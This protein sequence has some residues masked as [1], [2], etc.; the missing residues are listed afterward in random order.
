MTGFVVDASVTASWVLPD[1]NVQRSEA[2]R[3]RLVEEDAHVPVVW[4]AEAANALLIAERRG[5]VSAEDVQAALLDLRLSPIVVDEPD[6]DRIW[7]ETVRL[8]REHRLTVYDASYLE[9]ALRL[10]LPLATL[11][12][13]LSEAATRAGAVLA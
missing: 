2:L 12:R 13:R 5:R 11:D 6:R 7:S 1:E 8:A 4:P 3:R 10:A 9:L